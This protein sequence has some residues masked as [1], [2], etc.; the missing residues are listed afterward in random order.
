[1]TYDFTLEANGS[2]SVYAPNVPGLPATYN[3]SVS[4]VCDV[5]VVGIANLAA[6]P[7]TGGLGDSFTQGNGL[8]R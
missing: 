1:V 4:V 2:A 5:E 6:A 3:G 8:N 7:G